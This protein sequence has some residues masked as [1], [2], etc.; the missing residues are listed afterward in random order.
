MIFRQLF[1]QETWTYTYLLA[2]GDSGE[3]VLVDPVLEKIDRDARLLA[4]LGLA[5]K[6][7]LETHV[8]ADHVTGS[9]ALRER[10]GSRSVVSARGGARCADVQ[11]DD[12]D[13]LRFGRHTVEVLA[14]PGHT[15]GCVTYVVR[16][17]DLVRAFTGDALLVRGCGR[18]DFQEGDARTLFRSVRGRIFGLPDDALVYPGHDYHGHTLSTVGEEKRLNP[19]LGLDVGEDAFVGLMDALDLAY[20]R[21]IDVAVPANKACGAAPGSVR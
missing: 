12:G 4:D 19:R 5:L 13:R 8:H 2:D 21:R 6:Y 18:T 17:G 15:A 10:L 9:G 1:D 16:D 3:A 11:V 14:T 20:P 7:T